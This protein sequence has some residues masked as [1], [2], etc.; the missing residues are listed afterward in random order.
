MHAAAQTKPASLRN[1]RVERYNVCF[2]ANAKSR[3]GNGQGSSP[4]CGVTSI[5]ASCTAGSAC[6]THIANSYSDTRKVQLCHISA[7]C[8]DAMND[9]TGDGSART[10]CTFASG[11]ASLTFCIGSTTA[12]LGGGSCH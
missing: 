10:C 2:S 5:G 6:K 11:A 9:T 12:S 4:K 8:T 7:D 1:L 3:Q